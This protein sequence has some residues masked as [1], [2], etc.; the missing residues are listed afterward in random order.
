[1]VVFE[2]IEVI[3]SCVQPGVGTLLA[4]TLIEGNA[5]MHHDQKDSRSSFIIPETRD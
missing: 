4:T 5:S 2:A 1:V 3:Q